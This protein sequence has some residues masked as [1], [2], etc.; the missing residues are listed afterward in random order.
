MNKTFFLYLMQNQI[1]TCAIINRK[2]NA[3]VEEKFSI[4]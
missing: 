1:L 3:Y 2:Y 4:H